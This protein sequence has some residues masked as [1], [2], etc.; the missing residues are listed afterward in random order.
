MSINIL[1]FLLLI[2]HTTE[3]KVEEVNIKTPNNANYVNMKAKKIGFN[4]KLN[5]INNNNITML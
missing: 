1:C 2:I 3:E 5:P 4:F